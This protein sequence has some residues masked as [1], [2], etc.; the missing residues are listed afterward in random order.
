MQTHIADWSLVTCKYVI[1]RKRKQHYSFCNQQFFL[2]SISLKQTLSLLELEQKLKDIR[3]VVE[4]KDSDQ[5]ASYS[6]L[7]H[8]LMPD[9]ENPLASQVLDSV[10]FTYLFSFCFFVGWMGWRVGLE[11]ESCITVFQCTMAPVSLINGEAS[12][13]INQVSLS[14]QSRHSCIFF[15]FDR[16]QV[17]PSECQ[18]CAQKYSPVTAFSL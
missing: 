5:V 1:G 9:E 11:K 14:L 10:L 13:I 17:S 18:L 3:E 2:S 8:Y 4:H 6:P 16:R 15:R 7:C 12:S